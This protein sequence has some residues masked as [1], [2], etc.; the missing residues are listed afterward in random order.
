MAGT[1]LGGIAIPFCHGVVVGAFVESS[2]SQVPLPR[3]PQPSLLT[4]TPGNDFCP[5]R[6]CSPSWPRNREKSEL[7]LLPSFVRGSYGR[8]LA[9]FRMPEAFTGSE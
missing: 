1:S 3:Q 8:N 5:E 9:A 2:P 6:G 7:H 4:D